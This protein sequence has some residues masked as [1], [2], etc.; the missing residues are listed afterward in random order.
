MRTV[1]H[2]TANLFG[3]LALLAG[4]LLAMSAPARAQT[5]S[6]TP[7][8][9]VLAA[10][11]AQGTL[12]TWD[13]GTGIKGL[14][15]TLWQQ[16]NDGEETLLSSKA[17]GSQSVAIK[18]GETRVFKLYNFTKSRLLAST[19]VKADGENANADVV[20][21]DE[22]DNAAAPVSFS[23]TWQTLSGGAYKY[24]VI[25]KQSGKKVNGS[26]S[27]GNG[28]IFDGEVVDRKV[29]FSWTQDGG[30]EGTGEFTLSDD[31]Q[32]FTGSSTAFKPQKLTNT[33]NTY[34]ADFA[35]VWETVTDGRFAITLTLEQDRN[36]VTGTYTP[37]NGKLE[38][39]IKDRVL[40]FKW[41]SD[42]GQG[43]GRFIMDDLDGFSGSS[44]KGDNPDDADSTWSGKR[45]ILGGGGKTKVEVNLNGQW[46]V[47]TNSVNGPTMK[48]SL[49]QNTKNQVWGSG[50]YK[51]GYGPKPES[52][53]T[54]SE[55]T[56]SNGVLR[57]TVE[58]EFR[59]ERAELV[60]DASGKL[61]RGTMKTAQGGTYGI[62]AVFA[63][64]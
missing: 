53:V 25:L 13:A 54:I 29:T 45:K 31:G 40:R 12:V 43:T 19:I 4:I 7:Q 63:N 20:N 24:T 23:G 6:A 36:K 21:A 42:G 58:W 59:K 62:T 11:A 52:V 49:W 34:A 16:V 46:N 2:R 56:F 60:L 17:K 39:T 48:W 50:T 14:G 61:L 51:L 3:G 37:G 28:K 1:I 5:V 55:G 41:S 9:V 64:F 30:Y 33:W 44:N 35:G 15:A 38:G 57:C 18:V 32:G 26:F 27:P 22:A 47:V 8:N 10:G